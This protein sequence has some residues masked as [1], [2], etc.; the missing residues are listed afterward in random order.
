MALEQNIEPQAQVLDPMTLFEI[1]EKIHTEPEITDR[2]S[3]EM[4]MNLDAM[5]NYMIFIVENSLF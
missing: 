4:H 3:E 5:V 1:E 2:I